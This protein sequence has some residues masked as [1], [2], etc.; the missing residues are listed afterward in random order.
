MFADLGTLASNPYIVAIVV[1]LFALVGVGVWKSRS[2]KDSAD[3]MVAGRRLGYGVLVGTLLATWIGNGSL[4]GGAGLGY[5][6]GLAGA[7]S[8]AGAWI[9]I[10]LVYFIAQRVRRFG[11]VTVPDIFEARY[12]G[13]AAVL[14][15]VITVIAYLTIV[16]YQF[17]GGGRVLSIVTDGIIT[18]EAGI[19]ITA[20]FAIS[21]TVLAGMISVVYT[22]VV[23]GV[24]IIFGV[25]TTVVFMLFAVGGIGEV[26]AVA[27][28]AG[29][30][31]LFGNWA[32]ERATV[33]SAPIIAFS[34]FVPTMLLL[35]GD[36]N[37]YQRIFS[38]KSGGVAKK[39]VMLWVIGV[40][41]L[42]TSIYFLGLLGS[43]AATQGLIP[44]L[45][46][47]G[48]ADTVANL[49]ENI[50]P[51]L[52]TQVVPLFVGMALVS[53]MMAIIV[54]TADSFLLVP[55]TNLT[56]DI[57]QRYVSPRAPEGKVVLISR[58]MVLLLGFIAF[59]LVDQ[60]PTIL[61]AAYTAYLIYGAS[62]TPSLLAA[63]LWKRATASGAVASIVTGGAVT[64]IWTFYLSRQAYFGG[65]HPMLQE[66][67][68]PAVTLSIL[69]L[70][71][72]SLATRP[73]TAEQLEPFYRTEDVPDA[74]S[75]PALRPRPA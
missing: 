41:V 69:T 4:F 24:V 74:V 42:E 71:G 72:V 31:S 1:Y 35:M 47:G 49:S 12:G 73:P 65:W 62:I 67:T 10:V 36:A 28:A 39:A 34:F 58:I 7:W 48:T 22:D 15:T 16:S 44:E 54:S 13:P 8:S 56:R 68:Y 37:M 5:R 46:A 59:L 27:E 2:V 66:V 26:V 75:D 21:Y 14:A 3:F 51:T 25:L 17:R 63:F 64:L 52:A 9:G 18:V 57:Y 70:V 30:W 23:N 61:A 6:N 43:V 33:A 29:K 45:F 19:I 60:F 55:A 53:A 32:D 38:A 40:V 20:L 50:I 11:K